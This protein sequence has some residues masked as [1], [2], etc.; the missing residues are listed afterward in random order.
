[1]HYK[2]VARVRLQPMIDLGKRAEEYRTPALQTDEVRLLLV[3][4]SALIFIGQK[5]IFF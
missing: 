2:P 3:P 4:V 1:M 5:T